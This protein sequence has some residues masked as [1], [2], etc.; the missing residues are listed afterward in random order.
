V[1][2][3]LAQIVAAWPLGA[4]LAGAVALQGLYAGRRRSALNEAVHELRR[5]LQTLVLT[6]PAGDGADPTPIDGTVRMAATALERLER[7]INGDPVAPVRELM[8]V[9]PLLVSAV[10]RW[11][12]RAERAGASLTLSAPTGSAAIEADPDEL[13]RAVDNLIANAIEHGGGDVLLEA[14]AEGDR[15]ALAV[16][17]S[18][19]AGRPAASRRRLDLPIARALGRARRGHGLRI[20]RRIASVHGGGFRLRPT[21]RGTEAVIWLPAATR[22]KERT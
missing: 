22:A 21:R 4:S 15:I 10:G 18:G 20:V 8:A 19:C 9:R 11:R 16:L 6:M 12:S 5:P 7:E 14:R 17:D 2:P 1:R 13:E 3:E